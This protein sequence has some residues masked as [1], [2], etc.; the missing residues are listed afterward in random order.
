MCLFV[1]AIAVSIAE[2]VQ[3]L[4]CA[5]TMLQ[6]FLSMIL[7]ILWMTDQLPKEMQHTQAFWSLLF[8]KQ[9]RL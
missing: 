5:A 6:V 9:L 1:A 8:C 7:W 4:F 3:M 2:F